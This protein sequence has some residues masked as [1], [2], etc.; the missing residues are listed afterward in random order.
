M[1]PRSTWIVTADTRRASAYACGRTAR[2]DL[3]LD[4][5]TSIENSHEAEHERGRPML[6]GG[7][8][9]RGGVARS[10]AR[11]RPQAL[12]DRHVAE[13]EDRRFAREVAAWLSGAR[14]GSDAER[15][16]VFAPAG[17]LGLLRRELTEDGTLRLREAGLTRL[18]PHE[19]A[20]HSA[21]I[22]AVLGA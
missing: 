20:S 22:H 17:F 6:A 18:R 21:V 15:I 9:R 10:G 2:G 14:R 3:N 11:A 13:E 5:L 8:E 16:T 19:L 12:A 7:G 1:Q 4:A